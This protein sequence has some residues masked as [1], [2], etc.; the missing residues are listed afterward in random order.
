MTWARRHG[1]PQLIGLYHGGTG[2]ASKNAGRR[3]RES[4]VS[5]MAPESRFSLRQRVLHILPRGGTLP[6]ESWG[7]RHQGILIL[8]WAHALVI[9]FYALT[10]GYSLGHSLLESFVVPATAVIAGSGNLPR[11]ARTVAAAVGLLSSSA[12]LVHLSDG[13]IEMHF[14]FFVMVAV[15]SLYQEWLTFLVAVGYVFVHHGVMG[16]IDPDSVFNHPAAIAHPWTWAGVHAL[17]IAGISVACLVNWRLNESYLAKRRIAEARLREETRI[18]ERLEEVGRMLAA[19]LDLDHVVQRVTDVATELTSAHFGAF[20]Y[21]VLDDSGGSYLLYTLSGVPA[22]AFA[23]FPM[24]RATSV[25]GPT[26]AGEDPVRLD[27]VTADTRYGQNPPYAGMPAG[28]LPVRSYLA[29]PVKSRGTV[30][31]G[32]FF[33]HPRTRPVHRSRRAPRRRDRRPRRRRRAERPPLRRR[34]S[35]PR[36]GAACPRAAGHR[37]RSRAAPPVLLARPGRHGG[38]TGGV[39][40]PPGRRHLLG[41]HHRRSWRTAAGRGRRPAGGKRRRC[42]YLRRHR[43][44]GPSHSAGGEDRALRAGAPHRPRVRAPG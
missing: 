16:A 40:R 34:A 8:L 25:F 24:P 10:R 5:P 37:R 2:S 30:L 36:A 14:H 38:R 4:Q 9:P 44:S 20:F 35:C 42:R 39:H 11:R 41:R 1:G 19:D 17:F 29:V 6:A 27:D 18:V 21:N 32:L 33:G 3:V 13:L 23:G 28:H 12:V 43:S 7:R 15:V 26:F 31:G 22:E